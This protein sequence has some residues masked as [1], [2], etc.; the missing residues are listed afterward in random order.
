M[1]DLL[2]TNQLVIVYALD[3]SKAFDSVRQGGVL[4]KYLQLEM[5]HNIYNW[6]ESFFQDYSHYTKLGNEVS[7]FASIILCYRF[8]LK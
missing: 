2:D 3:F 4:D 8:M 5:L 7:E 6:I 1:S